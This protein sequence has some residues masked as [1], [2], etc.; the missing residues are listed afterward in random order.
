MSATVAAPL[1][2]YLSGIQTEFSF[3]T[4]THIQALNWLTTTLS[5]FLEKRFNGLESNI[6]SPLF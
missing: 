6:T 3:H 4:H 1:S 2:V 5:H